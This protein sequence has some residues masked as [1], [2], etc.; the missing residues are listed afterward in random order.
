VGGRGRGYDS[1][2]VAS[3]SPEEDPFLPAPRR[4]RGDIVIAH[5]S[6]I[7]VDDGYTARAHGG[8]GTR[9]LRHVLETARAARADIAL[10]VG[11][12]FEHNRLPREIV[13]QAARVLGDAGMEVV[14]LPGNH[15]PVMEGSVWHRGA[16]S[17][18][19]NVHIIGV[20]HDAAVPFPD[21]DLEIWGRPHTDYDDMAPLR[22]P[23]KRRT[24]WL[25]AAAHG[26]Y[27]PV[28]DRRV[29]ARS[30]WLFGDA[31]IAA[32]GADYL[33]L[34][35]WN[36]PVRVGNGAVPAWYSGSPEYA[37]TV[38][39]VRL[40]DADGAVSVTRRRIRWD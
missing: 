12:I 38:N 31:D 15:D 13:D 39:I 33:A 29:A 28:P 23:R 10:L 16:L 27:E 17:E 19:G 18:P 32:T 22:R 11:D 6:D 24:R 25:L 5:S 34:G 26:H 37:G 14:I 9:G 21:L 1:P 7:H 2:F 36:R 4:A 40:R 30:A 8:D 3:R 20:T 35:H